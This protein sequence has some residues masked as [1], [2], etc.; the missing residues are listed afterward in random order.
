MKKKSKYYL[1]YVSELVYCPPCIKAYEV[2]KDIYLTSENEVVRHTAVTGILQYRGFIKDP[3]C[4]TE[5]FSN[6]AS[7]RKFVTDN[8]DAEERKK[9]IALF[10]AGQL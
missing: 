7:F 6:T 4:T 1:S 9:I 5:I 2:L 3:M 8:G 10:E